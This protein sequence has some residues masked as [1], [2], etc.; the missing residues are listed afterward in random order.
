MEL[1][2]GM[3]V[4]S[5]HYPNLFRSIADN[6]SRVVAMAKLGPMAVSGGAPVP[7]FVTKLPRERVQRCNR[8]PKPTAA[9]RVVVVN[10]DFQITAWGMSE[11]SR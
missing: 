4:M 10:A 6:L 5:M 8:I 9:I 2:R 3:N 1:S 11:E 7:S